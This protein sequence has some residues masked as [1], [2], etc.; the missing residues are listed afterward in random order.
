MMA[1][2]R[3][4]GSS[5]GIA[6]YLWCSALFLPLVCQ[7]EQSIP[8]VVILADDSYPPYS[9][10]ADG[11]LQ[12]IYVELVKQAAMLLARDYDVTLMPVPWQRGLA[13]LEQGD[14]IAILPPYRLEK[15]RPYIARYSVPLQEEVVVAFCQHDVDLGVLSTTDNDGASLNVGVNA[16]FRILGADFLTAKRAGKVQIWEN[17]DTYANVIKLLKQRLDC[18]I[19]D[20]LSTHYVVAALPDNLQERFAQISEVREIMKRT[21]H[22]GYVAD[23]KKKFSYQADFIAKM[24]QA[25]LQILAQQLPK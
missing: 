15:E 13:A 22:I 14:A 10:L 20:R 6:I 12:G 11:E 25:L 8:K 19:N 7:A 3:K 1:P 9:F 18:Y 17:K 23:I 5:I 21:A 2:Q 24:D 16:G 4:F